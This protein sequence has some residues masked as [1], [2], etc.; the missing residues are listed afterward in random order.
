MAPPEDENL[1]GSYPQR[2]GHASWHAWRGLAL[3]ASA[4][5]VAYAAGPPLLR[6]AGGAPGVPPV[7]AYARSLQRVAAGM[8]AGGRAKVGPA[9]TAAA[10]GSPAERHGMS[11]ALG[12][13]PST[14][15]TDGYG[16][17]RLAIC[18]LRRC[19]IWV[20]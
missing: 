13:V 19:V 7:D 3:G 4:E 6:P 1:R 5:G 18:Q 17:E 14:L 20:R 16:Q 10:D 9:A 15:G 12:N 11:Q 8:R 2:Y